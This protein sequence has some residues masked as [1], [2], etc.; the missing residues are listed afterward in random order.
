M[1]VYHLVLQSLPLPLPIFCVFFLLTVSTLKLLSNWNLCFN[2]C[3][4][5]R[6]TQRYVPEPLRCNQKKKMGHWNGNSDERSQPPAF[7][8]N[9]KVFT[10][11]INNKSRPLR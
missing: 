5:D 11:F 4:W 8:D 6:R 1:Q 9:N 2:K 3:R 10:H 7:L